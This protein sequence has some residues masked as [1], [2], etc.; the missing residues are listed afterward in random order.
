MYVAV[1]YIFYF[2]LLYNHEN[3]HFSFAHS[4]KYRITKISIRMYHRYCAFTAY[5]I[6][7][8]KIHLE[9]KSA[10]NVLREPDK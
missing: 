9:N 3:L 2:L 6:A 1:L 5:V 4:L 10:Q 7:L 8:H